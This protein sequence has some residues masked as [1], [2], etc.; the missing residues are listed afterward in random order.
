MT[1][2]NRENYIS[3]M[4]ICANQQMYQNVQISNLFVLL[5]SMYCFML[6]PFVSEFISVLELKAL[7]VTVNIGGFT[8]IQC[9]PWQQASCTLRMTLTTSQQQALA[10]T[11]HTIPCI[12]DTS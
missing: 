3:N 12:T 6:S 7:R 10:P 11:L 2:G 4:P 5:Y 1:V 9:H 8:P